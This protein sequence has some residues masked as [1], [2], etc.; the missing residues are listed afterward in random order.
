MERGSTQKQIPK[1]F[2]VEMPL[3]GNEKTAVGKKEPKTG[4]PKLDN[5]WK[6]STNGASSFDGSGARLMLISPDGKEYDYA[7]R[8]EFE[9]MNNKE[10]YEALLAGLRIVQEM[11]IISL[12]I[13]ADSQLLVNQIKGLF[14]A[15]Q[16]TIK[17]YLQKVKEI[18]KGF[19]SYTSKHI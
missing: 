2:S 3:E 16:S 15:R 5:A 13:F 14:E 6:L 12:A 19:D 18:M 17:Q 11:E 8:F 9:T 4:N 7:L 1:D 10:E